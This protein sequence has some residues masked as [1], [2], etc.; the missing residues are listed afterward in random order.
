MVKSKVQSFYKVLT[1]EK[2]KLT[3]STGTLRSFKAFNFDFS[4]L[5]ALYIFKKMLK[6]HVIL[7]QKIFGAVY[8]RELKAHIFQ[9]AHAPLLRYQQKEYSVYARIITDRE[10]LNIGHTLSLTRIAI[11]GP[12]S[13]TPDSANLTKTAMEYDQSKYGKRYCTLHW[14]P[15]V[16]SSTVTKVQSKVCVFKIM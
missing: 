11:H 1:H 8:G 15:D 12:P 4:R 6:Q 2:S 10:R 13:A 16:T 9:K 3:L 14:K 7:T 5:M